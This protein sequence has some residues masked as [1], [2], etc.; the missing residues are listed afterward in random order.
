MCCAVSSSVQENNHSG[1]NQPASSSQMEGLPCS[2]D[3]R[4]EKLLHRL[5]LLFV[6]VVVVIAAASVGGSRL[7]AAALLPHRLQKTGLS[8]EYDEIRDR[9]SCWCEEE[10]DSASTG[11]GQR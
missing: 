8:S 10:E 1:L 7:G 3:L 6:V 4:P 9:L 2:V 5:L 11:I